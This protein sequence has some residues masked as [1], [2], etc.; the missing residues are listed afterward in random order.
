MIRFLYIFTLFISMTSFGQTDAV[1][2][3]QSGIDNFKL[4]KYKEAEQD[5]SDAIRIGKDSNVLKAAYLKKGL[6]LNE[7]KEFDKA[8]ICFS[9][10]YEL[11]KSDMLTLIDRGTT[12][13]YLNN[14]EKAKQDFKYIL[15]STAKDKS[16]ETSYYYLG[17]ISMQEG[18]YDKAIDY[19][20]SLIELNTTDFET[21]YLRGVAK[22]NK[23][24][25]EGS[26]ADYDKA[27]TYNPK[28]ME[29]YANRGTMKLNRIPVKDKIKENIDCLTDPCVDLIKAKE[30]GDKEIEDL[31]YLYCKKCK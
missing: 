10:A 3:I 8:I 17:R 18:N 2:K 21:Y 6:T 7:L 20:D 26:I 30:L 28:Y 19:F 12:Y 9:K 24:D 22:G 13:L 1:N 16:V 27:I 11:D 4:R 14:I 15:L 5:F 23:M 29:A 25:F 31:L